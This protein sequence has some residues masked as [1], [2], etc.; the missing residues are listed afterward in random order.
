MAR[1]VLSDAS[2]LI[3]L[4]RVGGVDWLRA[5]FGEVL[6]PRAVRAELLA[7]PEREPAIAEALQSS[8][9]RTPGSEPD[10]P[11]LPEHLGPGEQAC[12][13]LAMACVSPTLV[14]MD[15]RLARREALARGLRVAGT[16]RVIG[17]AQRTGLIVSARDVF[18]A[19]LHTD[20]RISPAVIVAVLAELSSET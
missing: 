12:I 1:V 3:G 14:L 11:P 5:L 7:G 8:W 16:A 6:V 9:L 10:G 19:L 20:F 18:E 13:R 17:L 15:D 4:S 2:P